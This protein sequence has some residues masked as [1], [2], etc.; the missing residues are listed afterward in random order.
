MR[1]E[2]MGKGPELTVKDDARIT[3][4]GTTLRRYKIDELPQLINVLRGNMSLIGPR[5]SLAFEVSHYRPW[6]RMRSDTLPGMTGLWQV[7]GKNKTTFKEMLRLDVAYVQGLSVGLDVRIFL[8]TFP[9]V[10][11]ELVNARRRENRVSAC[12]TPAHLDSP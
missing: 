1:P 8:R 6:Q 12:G 7:S 4:I 3:R 9:T 11:S 5:P 2:A 10:V